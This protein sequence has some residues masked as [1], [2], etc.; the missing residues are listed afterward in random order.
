MGRDS[1]NRIT[2]STALVPSSFLGY[3]FQPGMQLMNWAVLQNI[4]N[5]LLV[6]NHIFFGEQ[7]YMV[8]FLGQSS[9]VYT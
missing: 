4:I 2:M 5:T 1:L 3:F 7:C 8:V 6:W 9:E